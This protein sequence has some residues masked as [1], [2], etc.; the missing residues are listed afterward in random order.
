MQ[1]S[2]K[3]FLLNS[4]NFGIFPYILI[5]L[6]ISLIVVVGFVVWE[7]FINKKHQRKTTVITITDDEASPDLVNSL[8]DILEKN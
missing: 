4:G 8:E 5:L 3:L 6:I 2:T 1:S 7:I